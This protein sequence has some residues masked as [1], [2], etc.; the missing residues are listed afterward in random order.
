MNT[1]YVRISDVFN[2]II[3]R[4][5]KNQRGYSWKETQWDEL[6][7]DINFNPHKGGLK[8]KFLGQIICS[9]TDEDLI[10]KRN[11]HYQIYLLED[12]QQRLVTFTIIAKIIPEMSPPK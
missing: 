1:D 5:P 6:I 9:K 10:A 11:K 4:I 8:N 3:F 12:G 7:A 2:T